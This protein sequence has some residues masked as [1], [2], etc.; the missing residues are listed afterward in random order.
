MTVWA[1]TA[2]SAAAAPRHVSRGAS[3]TNSPGPPLE[4]TIHG[5]VLRHKPPGGHHS[6]GKGPQNSNDPGKQAL[7]GVVLEENVA[8]PEFRNYAAQRPDVY[9][10]A[11][12]QAEHHLRR[13]V[14]A[15]LNVTSEVVI[16]EARRAEVNDFDFA[17]RVR[18]HEDVLGL[19]VCVDEPEA[20]D[21]V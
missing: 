10:L 11:I 5:E 17:A 3:A 16:Y 2:G 1:D 20:V 9:F 12:R 8:C 19:E 15:R 13:P 4:S 7:H 14:G 21:V 6:L 18:L